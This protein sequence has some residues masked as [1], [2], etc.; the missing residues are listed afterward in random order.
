MKP[1]VGRL[2]DVKSILMQGEDLKHTSMRRLLGP[3]DGF[4]GY[5][6]RVFT[7]QPDG[8]TPQHTH[9]W[10]HINLVVSGEGTLQTGEYFTPIEQGSYAYV[11]PGMLHQ[12][13]NTGREPLVFMCIV[14]E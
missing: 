7:V 8:F 9:D 6:M 10:P 12:F 11:P 2:E 1:I 5:A 14:P 13:R 4:S 3:E